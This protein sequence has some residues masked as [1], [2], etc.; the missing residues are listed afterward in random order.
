MNFPNKLVDWIRACV[1]SSSFSFLINGQPSKWIRN[2]RGIRQGDPISP[3]L[4]ILVSQNLTS[5]MNFALKHNFIPG[6]DNRFRRNFNHLI[7]AN[8]LVIVT[9]ASR[10]SAKSCMICLNIY[11]SLIG[12]C[13]NINKSFVYFPTQ[14]NK[15]IVAP[16]CKILGMKA[17]SFP[18]KNLGAQI[19]LSRIPVNQ[20]Q[21]LIDKAN[22]S[23]SSCNHSKLW[24]VGKLI[25]INNV[26][27]SIPNYL[28]ASCVSLMQ[29]LSTFL[30]QL[31]I[32]SGLE[33]EIEVASILFIGAILLLTNLMVGLGIHNLRNVN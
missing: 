22:R 18:F 29:S 8:D 12:Q 1:S 13:P 20:F 6:F 23:V 5:L 19:I 10:A 9:K 28:L 11:N 31:G 30:K 33:V 25:L 21:F 27:L 4:F 17:G 26:F 16:V 2:T 3:Y 15:R 7:F 24:Y 14:L 32:S